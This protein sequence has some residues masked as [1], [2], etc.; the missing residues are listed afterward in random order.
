MWTTIKMH[1]CCGR[2]V[3]IQTITL[4]PI[5]ILSKKSQF[6]NKINFT[7]CIFLKKE[8]PLSSH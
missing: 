1:I 4:K 7:E 2:D 5:N 3:T 8:K 6:K